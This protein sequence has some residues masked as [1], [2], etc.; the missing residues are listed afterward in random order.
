MRYVAD[1]N[2]HVLHDDVMRIDDEAGT[3]NHDSWRRSC[4][5]GDRDVRMSDQQR[6][7][8][9]SDRSTDLKDDEPRFGRCLNTMAKSVGR[10]RPGCVAQAGYS[11]NR[12]AA[13][14]TSVGAIAL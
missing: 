4:L 2:A 11:A 7:L 1:T 10:C 12:T 3:A 9:E 6:P 5:A 8:P 14:A 13:A